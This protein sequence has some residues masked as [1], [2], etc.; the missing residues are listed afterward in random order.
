MA[1]NQISDEM[2]FLNAPQFPGQVQ[3][4]VQQKNQPSIEE[5]RKLIK[6]QK[7]LKGFSFDA[8][9]GN[10][11]FNIQLSGTA[12]LWLGLAMYGIEEEGP[13]NPLCCTT[14]QNISQVVLQ[15]NN[16]IVID[17]L[18]PNFISFGL[19]DT[20][21]YFI[22][23]PLSGTDEISVKFTNTGINTETCRIVVYYI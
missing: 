9:V 21:Y 15:I 3:M 20:E 1:E 12:R 14:F 23:R 13:E 7:R 4:G 6:R 22:P 18:D 8:P 19:N 11:T 10:S 17:Q 16:E 5:I 2:D